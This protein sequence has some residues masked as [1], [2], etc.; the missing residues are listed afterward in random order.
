MTRR[1]KNAK[2]VIYALLFAM[3]PLLFAVGHFQPTNED[4]A[5]ALAYIAFACPFVAIAI[6][7]IF[8]LPGVVRRWRG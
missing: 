4:L 2:A 5:R 3:L 7:A 1:E 8:L 6:G